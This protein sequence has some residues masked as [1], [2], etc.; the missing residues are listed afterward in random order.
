MINDQKIFRSYFIF[1]YIFK[2]C[3]LLQAGWF[4]NKKMKDHSTTSSDIVFTK[5]N[6]TDFQSIKIWIKWVY[7]NFEIWSRWCILEHSGFCHNQ[8]HQ[9]CMQ[10]YV[11]KKFL[12][13]SCFSI[14]FD[15]NIQK[16]LSCYLIRAFSIPNQQ[17]SKYHPGKWR[18]RLNFNIRLLRKKYQKSNLSKIW[19]VNILKIL[20]IN[21][22]VNTSI[23]IK[24][25]IKIDSI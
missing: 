14:Y 22:S 19:E 23:R 3:I 24:S 7:K 8:P 13:N 15:F 4:R 5:K 17:I 1:L 6:F 18:I 2:F 16:L 10:K 21:K 20:T 9:N 12:I 11:E 25:S